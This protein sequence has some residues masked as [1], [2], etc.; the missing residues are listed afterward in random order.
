M[1]FIWDIKDFQKIGVYRTQLNHCGPINDLKINNFENIDPAVSTYATCSNDQTIRVW[2]YY[3]GKGL[4]SLI[5]RNAYCKDM[6]HIL[7][8]EVE[9]TTSFKHSV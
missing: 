2:N 3:D 1:L 7:Y 5:T 6:A 4:D 8:M 9:N